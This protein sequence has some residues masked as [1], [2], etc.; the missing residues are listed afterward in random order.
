MPA[1]GK[2]A[3]S[4]SSNG[5]LCPTCADPTCGDPDDPVQYFDD[6]CIGEFMRL[7][8]MDSAV[9][10]NEEFEKKWVNLVYASMARSLDVSQ[11]SYGVL[12]DAFGLDGAH[13]VRVR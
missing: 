5:L 13:L 2:Q 9:P 4:P 7:C 6:G 10:Q 3:F 1:R 11:R 12:R 8:G